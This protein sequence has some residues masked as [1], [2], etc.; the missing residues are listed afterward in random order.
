M[1]DVIQ[2][3]VKLIIIREQGTEILLGISC[4]FSYNYSYSSYAVDERPESNKVLLCSAYWLLYVYEPEFMM[5]K[6]KY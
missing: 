1:F 2:W 5:Q 4:P 6:I 3:D